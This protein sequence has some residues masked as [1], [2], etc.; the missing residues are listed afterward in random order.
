M[1][2]IR[3]RL[4]PGWVFL[5][6]AV[7][8][9]LGRP[10]PARFFRFE[11]IIPEKDGK[12]V[13]GIS[14]LF[15]DRQGYL[16]FGTSDGLARHDGYRFD[17]HS[18]KS[19]DNALPASL[20]AYPVFEDGAGEIW[21]GTHGEGLLRYNKSMRSFIQYRHDPLRPDSLSGDIVLAVQEDRSGVLW[22]GTRLNG[23]SRFDRETGAFR[24]FPLEPDA[25]TIWDLLA[26]SRGFLWAGTQD[27]GLFRVDPGTEEVINF[28]FILD[29]PRSLGSNTVWSL[30]ESPR[31]TIWV[32][33][34]G[35]GL[36]EYIPEED[37]FSRFSGDKDHP[38]DLATSTITAI[39]ED[40]A[41]RVW[42]GTSWNGLRIWDRNNGD[43]IICKHD[44]EDPETLSDDHITSIGADASGIMWI[45]TVRGGIN[46]CLAD[47]VK[48]RHFKRNRYDPRSLS[49]NDVRALF[50]DK[51]G[52]LW[53]GLD[54]G[55]ERVDRER[56]VRI[57]INVSPRGRPGRGPGAVLAMGEDRRGRIW[58]G[59]EEGGL[60]LIDPRTGV[61][62]S[63]WSG[64]G[65]AGSL[66]HN[67][68]RAVV[69]DLTAPGIMWIGTNGGLNRFD[70]GSGRWEIV[71]RDPSDPAS[72]SGNF[73]RAITEDRR[74]RLWVGTTSGLNRVDKVTRRCVRYLH[75]IEAP[76]GAGISSS[77]INWI[78]ESRDG[79]LWI[80]TEAGLNR[81]DPEEN[82]WRS[83]TTSEGL[84]GS[85]VCGILED[86]S[87][88]L[89][90]STNRGLARFDPEAETFTKF[91]LH[92]GIQENVFNPGACFKASDGEMFF[93]GVNGYNSFRPEDIRPRPFIPPVVWTSLSRGDLDLG[94]GDPFRTELG[95]QIPYKIGFV[96]LH[97]AALCYTAPDL[98]R[99][100]YKIEPRDED[101]IDLGFEHS[102]SLSLGDPGI[103]RLRVKASNPD[104]IWNEAGLEI[105]VWIIPP[106]WRTGWFTVVIVLFA[107]SG[108]L[109]LVRTWKKLKAASAAVAEHV[110]KAV[111][112]FRLTPREEEILR[113]ILEGASNREIEKKLFISPSTV[114]N[115]VYNIYQKLGV[116]NRLELINLVGKGYL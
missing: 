65:Q 4:V 115:H 5:F 43:Y 33:T 81:F 31:G 29:N 82:E 68:V 74:G 97:F 54:A 77:V 76:R 13:M 104:G 12:P 9:V 14:S 75:D 40:K 96:T 107:L 11:H 44:P 109:I 10:Q 22:V 66:A 7:I 85:V 108:L 94:P 62:T 103:Y 45:G 38:R 39:S 69:E 42:I 57:P 71:A 88:S 52:H 91:G 26:D 86:D 18:P 106:F 78:H 92:D 89:W 79:Y 27:C 99:F 35:G 56:A 93:G 116:K 37:C 34:N 64:S 72:L 105:P 41:G 110:D 25:V 73:V 53:V 3:A 16:W 70:T 87:G 58:L 61:L 114:R 59:T 83:F 51:S 24:R 60:L 49:R 17:F 113:L 95:L 36:N 48:F 111:E 80:G 112:K 21:I 47:E 101:W 15:Q 8:P 2:R 102:V 19:G 32:G 67:T 6:V 46:K 84:P 20:G 23:L 55:L 90:I 1:M 63:H 98:N 30:G 100:A 50:E 28:R